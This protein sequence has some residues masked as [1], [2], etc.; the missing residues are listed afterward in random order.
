MTTTTIIDADNSAEAQAARA[1]L[2]DAMTGSYDPRTNTATVSFI[3]GENPNAPKHVATPHVMKV[4]RWGVR[5]GQEIAQAWADF[6][7]PRVGDTE[8]AD[9]CARCDNAPCQCSPKTQAPTINH[10]PVVVGD[11]HAALFEIEPKMAE[12]PVDQ[13]RAVWWKQLMD[14]PEFASLR[15]KTMLDT[16][17][18]ELGSKSLCDQWVAYVAEHPEHK[19]NESVGDTMQRMRSTSKALNQAFEDVTAAQDTAAGLGLGDKD[20]QIN[21][22]DLVSYFNRV[23]DDEFLRQLMKMAGRMRT[24]AQTLQRTKTLHG[25]DDTVGV[26]LGGDIARLIP[27]ELGQLASGVPELELLALDRLARGQSMCRKYR[28]KEQLGKGPI[29]VVV[30]ESGSM[31]GD[32]IM[33]AKALAL[34]LAWV[35]RQQKRWI[36]MVG[37]S[38]GEVGNWVAFPPGDMDQETL[39][40]WLT[41][42]YSGGTTLDVPLH[43]LP[44]VYW[45]AF[46]QMGLQRGRTDVVLITD[47]Q[48]D[49]PAEMIARY[50]EWAKAE[51]VRTY[52]IIIGQENAGDIAQ[53]A[54]RHW[55]VPDLGNA[56]AAI[57]TLLSI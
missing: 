47:A 31:G 40:D 11:A 18:S 49:A 3:E 25:R 21:P 10:D 9:Y 1:A 29:V 19:P 38:G 16:G 5:R 20:G 28:A 14:T 17:L 48:V 50:V 57:E 23:K 44:F 36:A 26:E 41:H 7:K 42:F 12:Q 53:F 2:A 6:G 52:G 51:Q 43:E 13:A 55:C 24:L 15:S 37:F 30:D 56:D 46:M 27:S 32:P 8:A 45:P 54:T 35:A 4:D 39:I 22:K 33:T 34:A